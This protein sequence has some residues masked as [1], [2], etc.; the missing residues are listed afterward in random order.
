[1]SVLALSGAA[2]VVLGGVLAAL[3]LTAGLMAQAAG[4]ALLGAA[5]V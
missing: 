2:V 1:M 5:G 4:M 3:R